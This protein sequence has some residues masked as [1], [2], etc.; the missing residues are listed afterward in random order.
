MEADESRL[1]H[2]LAVE[3][4]CERIEELSRFIQQH[5]LDPL[6][7]NDEKYAS[8]LRVLSHLRLLDVISNKLVIDNMGPR[9]EPVVDAGQGPEIAP[10]GNRPPSLFDY[11][12]VQSQHKDATDAWDNGRRNTENTHIGLSSIVEVGM[13]PTTDE[14]SQPAHSTSDGHSQAAVRPTTTDWTWPDSNS[15]LL[16]MLPTNYNDVEATTSLP[17][18]SDN[19]AIL[20]TNGPQPS[21]LV[22]DVDSDTK[23]TATLVKQLSARI[24]SL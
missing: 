17:I 13:T 1:S 5:S 12:N 8:L 11:E 23:I 24:G 20:Q 15:Y 4:L 2:R 3:L 6:P 16:D 18:Q 19:A 10:L 7:M 21:P 22:D 9:N 14:L